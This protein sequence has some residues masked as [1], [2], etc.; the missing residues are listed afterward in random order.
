MAII[1]RVIAQSIAKSA[2]QTERTC[3]ICKTLKPISDYYLMGGRPDIYCKPCR[4]QVNRQWTEKNREAQRE[5]WNKSKRESA[6]RK[7]AERRKQQAAVNTLD[8][9][10]HEQLILVLVACGLENKDIGK[11][12]G[13]SKWTID[14]RLQDIYF[15]LGVEKRTEAVIAAL[16]SK[17]LPLG[18]IQKV[19]EEL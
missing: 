3:S 19:R 17:Q 4:Y 12:I 5:I 7:R 9:T 10:E 8:L 18:L 6:R 13:V 2:P 16:T 14:R 1:D 11:R 15:K